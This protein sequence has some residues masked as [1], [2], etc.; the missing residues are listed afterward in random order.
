[1]SG[2]VWDLSGTDDQCDS[3]GAGHLIHWIQFKLSMQEPSTVIP[4]T[5][6]VDDDG[7]VHIEGD[8]V[9]L[10]R[11]NHRPALLQDALDQFEGMAVWK[12]RWQILAVP[13]ESFWGGARSVFS[14]AP[15]DERRECSAIRTSTYDHHVPHAPSPTNLPPLR[16]AGRYTAGKRRARRPK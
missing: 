1:M 15:Q 7:L 6:A 3:H 5:A 16:I 12:P 11:W 8:D 4:V 9:S 14:L 13:T 10:I 2:Y